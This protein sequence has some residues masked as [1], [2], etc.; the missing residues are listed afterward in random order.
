MVEIASGQTFR[1]SQEPFF[2]SVWP[3]G[4]GEARHKVKQPTEEIVQVYYFI[5]DATR[6][7]CPLPHGRGLP[8]G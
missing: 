2:G 1:A 5:S 8:G 3:D 7:S 4:W 6:P